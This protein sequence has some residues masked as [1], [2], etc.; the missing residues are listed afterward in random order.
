MLEV[1][2]TYKP[3]PISDEKCRQL[4]SMISKDLEHLD[5]D[6]VSDSLKYL[7]FFSCDAD[8]FTEYKCNWR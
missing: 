6:E 7:Y 3:R 4:L 5:I 2:E 1:E 8:H